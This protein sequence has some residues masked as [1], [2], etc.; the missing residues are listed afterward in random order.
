MINVTTETK[1]FS[2]SLYMIEKNRNLKKRGFET[3]EWCPTSEPPGGGNFYY[4]LQLCPIQ[5]ANGMKRGE[6]V[7]QTN[8]KKDKAFFSP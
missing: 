6:F 8:R 2:I 7:N 4:F 1:K 3:Q 5:G